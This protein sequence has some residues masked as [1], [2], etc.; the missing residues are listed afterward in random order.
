MVGKSFNELIIL[1]DVA[2]GLK[3][4]GHERTVQLDIS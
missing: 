4:L 1:Y 3:K 2:Q